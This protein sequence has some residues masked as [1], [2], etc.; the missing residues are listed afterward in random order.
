MLFLLVFPRQ[1][2]DGVDRIHAADRDAIKKLIVNLMLHSPDSIQKQLSDAV[3][4]IG[5][6]DFPTKW[7]DLIDQMVEKFNTGDFHVINGVLHTAH[8]LFKRY[9]YEFK[10]QTLWTEIKFVLDKFAKPLT[11]L[12]LVKESL[13]LFWFSFCGCLSKTYVNEL[14]W[15]SC[16]QATMNLTQVHANNPEA[17]KVIYNSLVI[18]CK[19]FYSLNFQVSTLAVIKLVVLFCAQFLSFN[20]VPTFVGFTRIFR[21]QHGRMD[22]EFPHFTYS[23][24]SGFADDG[25]IFYEYQWK[26]IFFQEIL[27]SN[28]WKCG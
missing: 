9:R 25:E 1:D 12:F 24:S 16:S 21:R 11:D 4:I 26:L 14:N 27:V 18:L 5:K 19:V 22:D 3:S 15:I 28:L 17:L 7:P 20:I 2:E 13:P 10:S 6:H 23:G 8:S